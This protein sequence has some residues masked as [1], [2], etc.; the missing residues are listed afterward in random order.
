M[1]WRVS[2]LLY[3][4]TLATNPGIAVFV[5]KCR[6]WL[7]MYSMLTCTH[8]Q[9]ILKAKTE[10]RVH[11]NLALVP[12]AI[13]VQFIV[14]FVLSWRPV[15]SKDALSGIWCSLSEPEDSESELT[16][17][18]FARRWGENHWKTYSGRGVFS[19][20]WSPSML[21]NHDRRLHEYHLTS[22]SWRCH[23][24]RSTFNS[25]SDSVNLHRNVH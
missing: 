3:F 15:N 6:L 17:G 21:L 7:H 25:E 2:S 19:S 1:T 20:Y 11:F 4:E 5:H 23:M 12:L 14:P 18:N 13:G 10:N 24:T 22:H 16:H 9:R 8:V